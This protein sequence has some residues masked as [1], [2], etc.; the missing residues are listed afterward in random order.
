M[1]DNHPANNGSIT[2]TV[3]PKQNRMVAGVCAGLA[4]RYDWD[5][6]VVRLLWVFAALSASIGFWAY[7][8]AWMILPDEDSNKRGFEEISSDIRG[9]QERKRPRRRPHEEFNPY[10]D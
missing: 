9:A 2:D 10:E 3:R 7:L 5:V 1:S 6:N 8:I 4:R